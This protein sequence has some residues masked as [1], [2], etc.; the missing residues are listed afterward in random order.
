MS[1]DPIPAA[2]ALRDA[3]RA[4]APAGPMP[5]GIA[6][7]TLEQGV[8]VQVA[9]ASLL[10][11]N[12]PGGFKI[13]ATAQRM[14]DYL[15]VSEPIAGFMAVADI[16]CSRASLAF[17]AYRGVGVECEIGLRLAAD[18]PP[19]PCS[20]A[21]AQAAVGEVFAAIEIVE[22]RSGKPPLGDLGAVGVP[23][24][25][26]DQ[27]YH[28]AAVIGV[29][30]PGW[31]DLD[32]AAIAGRISVNGQQKA[33]GIGADL[34]GHPFDALAWLAGCP[35]AAG[36]GG[37]RAGQVIMLGSVTP[38]IWLDGPCIVQVGFDG[39]GEANVTFT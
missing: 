11:A 9:H 16:H 27:M 35:T 12:P 21:Q 28:A 31:R 7:N 2:H 36:F 25:L 13:G 15:G 19:G 24:L 4:G 10:G 22:N 30:A 33:N 8:A 34:L 3:R 39:L 14:R 38:P 32:L 17:A 1:Y 26:A 29:P 18:L 6:P 20:R 23:T 5:S 37:L